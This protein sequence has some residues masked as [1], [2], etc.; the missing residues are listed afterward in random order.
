MT[1]PV[2][3]IFR[4]MQNQRDILGLPVARVETVGEWPTAEN[5][6]GGLHRCGVSIPGLGFD[7]YDTVFLQ[8]LSTEKEEELF[9]TD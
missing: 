3:T 1:L 5:P 9:N 6:K 7:A 2:L 4:K 8:Q